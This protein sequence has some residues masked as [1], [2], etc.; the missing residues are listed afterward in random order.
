MKEPILYID[1][2]Q[3]NLDG[4]LLTFEKEYHIYTAL[5][6]IEG[7]KILKQHLV[8]VVVTDQRMP[9]MKGTDFLE[10]VANKF[11]NTQRIIL[12]AYTDSEDIIDA[13]NKGK[14]FS[15]LVKPWNKRDVDVTFSKALEIYNLRQ[16]NE[17]LLSELKQANESLVRYNQELKE[18]EEKFS[19][20]FMLSPDFKVIVTYDEG[21][22]LDVNEEFLKALEYERE[23]V[24]NHTTDELG[25]LDFNRRQKSKNLLIQDG[26]YR[27]LEVEIN[28]KT[29]KRLRC[30]LSGRLVDIKGERCII[31][32][33]VDITERRRMQ[34]ELEK[35]RGLLLAAIEQSPSGILIADAP[36]V[37]IRFANSAALGI[38]GDAKR[39]LT[40]IP[41]KYHPE[42]WKVYY[43]DGRQFASQDLPLSKAVLEGITSKNIEAIIHYE[44]GEE[45]WVSCN[46]APIYDISGNVTA[47]IVIFHDITQQKK[48]EKELEEYRINLEKL[49]DERTE[50]IQQIN[51]ELAATNEELNVAVE[52]LNLVNDQL[53]KENDIRR[54]TELELKKY[55]EQLEE[56]VLKR[57]N[58]LFKSEERI[59]I[60]SNNLPG[61]AIFRGYIG[62][63]NKYIITYASA[64]MEEI[65]GTTVT[66]IIKDLS[67]VSKKVHPDDRYVLTK[68]LN[69][70]LKNMQLLDIEFRL[71]KSKKETI[72]IQLKTMPRFENE[73]EIWFDGYIIDITTRKLAESA[74]IENEKKFRLLF[75]N[76]NDGIFIMR[77]DKF[78]SC[79]SKTLSMFGCKKPEQ[80][81]NHTPYEFSPEFQPDGRASKEKAIEKITESL[82]GK[83]N[84]F[85][86]VHKRLN[87]SLFS[88]EIS[89]SS[90]VIDN[91]TFI[92]AIVRDITERKQMEK[93]I[94]EA[95]IDTEEKERARFATN[96]H[97]DIGPLLSS[98]KM[99]INSLP[100]IKSKEKQDFI[101]EQVNEIV[102]EAIQS[103]KEI[104]NDLSPHILKNYG[105]NSA[106]N[107]FIEKV[108]PQIKLNY[109]N[110]IQNLRFPDPIET[111]IYRI[112]KELINNTIKHAGAKSIDVNLNY[113][114]SVLSL[115]YIDDGKGID[116]KKNISKGMG[117]NN[118]INR[119]RLLEGNY[120]F[121]EPQNGGFGFELRV[122]TEIIEEE[123]N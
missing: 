41:V 37:H 42:Y 40:D 30:I 68:R 72:W 114:H 123:I 33:I 11:P 36:D 51:S 49:V 87:G 35:T 101:I 21:V 65:T 108:S 98:I 115:Y 90:F 52:E 78:I 81:I 70:S 99:Y 109:N 16:E 85:E 91:D 58:D 25:Y 1:D 71:I 47:G 97:D 17:N 106:I 89:L 43:P 95:V 112:V 82:Q 113:D 111:N 50:K 7:L 118:L 69:E 119:T 86:W 79:N 64:Q 4:F 3:A 13:I 28:T 57:T 32:S 73:N 31:E 6:A 83:L 96:L 93:K 56:L 100:K 76:A 14:V 84:I 45:R 122:Q 24:I 23:E 48:S 38:R 67:S 102:K 80:I 77:D 2:E 120:S 63:K 15:Y 12:S 18:S 44:N 8:K 92:Q 62:A 107:T 59:R 75:E 55:K 46:A 54:E 105:L 53:Q 116:K 20:A 74:L 121:F 61:G 60:L 88:A 22:I 39:K 29:G 110:N 19:S 103:T 117:M 10:Q 104:S 26:E 94:L 9:G 27:N 34:R 5:S 66:A